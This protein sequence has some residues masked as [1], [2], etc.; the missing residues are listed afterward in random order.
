MWLGCVARCR[1]RIYPSVQKFHLSDSTPFQTTITF[2]KSV[3]RIQK[4]LNLNGNKHTSKYRYRTVT[5]K[6]RNHWKSEK[7]GAR[8]TLLLSNLFIKSVIVWRGMGDLSASYPQPDCEMGLTHGL[9][10]PARAD[11]RAPKEE[12]PATATPNN[13]AVAACKPH[14]DR[15]TRY[16]SMSVQSRSKVVRRSISKW[17]RVRVCAYLERDA[18]L[19]YLL[20]HF[21]HDMS[22]IARERGQ[23][24]IMKY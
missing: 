17:S 13:T 7:S 19:A 22:I 10:L 5:F 11:R 12:P 3:S 24:C 2:C 8:A 9:P 4:S 14:S 6:Q 21:Y 15:C 18:F 1:W 23:F 16:S 20:S